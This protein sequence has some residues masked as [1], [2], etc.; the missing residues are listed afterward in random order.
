MGIHSHAA[1]AGTGGPGYQE[2]AMLRADHSYDPHV[3]VSHRRSISHGGHPRS[4]R[5]DTG[6]SRQNSGDW[7]ASTS[8]LEPPP[9]RK[10]RASHEK[11]RSAYTSPHNS[12]PASPAPAGES[13]FDPPPP[14]HPA[15]MMHQSP[16]STPAQISEVPSFPAF[17]SIDEDDDVPSRAVPPR[18]ASGSAFPAGVGP[19]SYQAAHLAAGPPPHHAFVYHSPS[20]SVGS[21]AAP[22]SE[23][24]TPPL[25]GPTASTSSVKAGKRA[26]VTRE[27]KTTQATIDA[28]MRRRNPGTQAKFAW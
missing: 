16:V 6:S 21:Q 28:A 14:A 7:H 15:S 17:V 1:P 20:P 2:A 8:Y 24:E 27:S 5:N 18:T 13:A 3:G 9:R 23:P 4:S 10:S 26:A 12:R 22:P 19:T 25:R 11:S